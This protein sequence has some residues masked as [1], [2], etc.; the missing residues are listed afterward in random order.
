[1]MMGSPTITETFTANATW[2][3]PAT[4][5]K[6]FKI[7]GSGRAG[8]AP[9]YNLTHTVN[10]FS[11]TY[12][13]ED[14]AGTGSGGYI[15]WDS[16][17]S[18][19]ATAMS[20]INDSGYTVCNRVTITFYN[21]P[22]TTKHFATPSSTPINPG[23]QAVSSADVSYIGTAWST[24]TISGNG[25][26]NITYRYLDSGSNGAAATG[27]G[28]SFPGGTSASPTP[29]I[30]TFTNVT[31]TPGTSYPIVVPTGGYVKITYSK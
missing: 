1:M 2:V 3:A 28:R 26:A 17:Q 6:I 10:I 29:P 25:S 18:Y 22:T 8:T 14:G 13:E 24:G 23:R 27:F 21:G 9:G 19:V 15:T 4:T 16:L 12:R 20:N 30:T 11:L 7:E 31:V 5:N